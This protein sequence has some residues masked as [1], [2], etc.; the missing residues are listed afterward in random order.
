MLN[1]RWSLKMYPNCSLIEYRM[2][3]VTLIKVCHPKIYCFGKKCFDVRDY[4]LFQFIQ[5]WIF[6][7]KSE[8]GPSI[9]ALNTN[10]CRHKLI[11]SQS[12]H[13]V[14]PQFP[15]YFKFTS[16]DAIKETKK[17]KKSRV[18]RGVKETGY[19]CKILETNKLKITLCLC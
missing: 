3:C 10:S 15:A 18:E 14:K 8:D 19:E 16:Y 5:Q 1:E 4:R 2:Y 12:N 6:F 11:F 17:L 9:N 7:G 13:P